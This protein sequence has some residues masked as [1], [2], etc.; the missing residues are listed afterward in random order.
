MSKTLPYFAYPFRAVN[1]KL[2]WLVDRL[3]GELRY[4]VLPCDSA[5]CSRSICRFRAFNKRIQALRYVLR[6]REARL[7]TLTKF[8]DVKTAD[9]FADLLKKYLRKAGYTA[10]LYLVVEPHAQGLLHA[11][12]YLVSEATD[13]WIADLFRDHVA[14]L[15]TLTSWSQLHLSH[16]PSAKNAGYLVKEAETYIARHLELNGGR[17]H[18]KATPGFFRWAGARSMAGCIKAEH[19]RARAFRAI[20]AVAGFGK[21]EEL[22]APIS[23]AHVLGALAALLLI[24]VQLP[25]KLA[26]LAFLLPVLEVHAFADCVVIRR[27]GYPLKIP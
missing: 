8:E 20:E 22:A 12:L 10:E 27:I 18:R 16:T 15:L 6:N 17:L 19:R 7:I 25:M 21:A 24:K 26:H 13:A 23:E 2:I 14:P 11:H 3:T 4:D 1:H 5:T 9:L